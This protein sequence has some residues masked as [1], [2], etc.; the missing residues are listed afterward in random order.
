MLL[1][2]WSLISRFP[3]S[4]LRAPIA[5]I[6]NPGIIALQLIRLDRF[7]GHVIGLSDEFRA[8]VRTDPHHPCLSFFSAAQ[9]QSLHNRIL[10][11][12]GGYH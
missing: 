3:V 5:I 1:S 2:G 8:P 6:Q 7:A 4:A 9:R 12:I 10:A 11:M